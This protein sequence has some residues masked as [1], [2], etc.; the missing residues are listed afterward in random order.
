MVNTEPTQEMAAAK[1]GDGCEDG[2]QVPA[3][4]ALAE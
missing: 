4:A 3:D 2:P 1:A